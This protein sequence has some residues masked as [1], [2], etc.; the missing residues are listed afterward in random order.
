MFSPPVLLIQVEPQELA[1]SS[2]WVKA[3]EEKF[4]YP[5]LF[6]KLSQTFATHQK[7]KDLERSMYIHGLYIVYPSVLNSEGSVCA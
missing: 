2:F 1:E 7:G 3:R 4:E 6:S 5:D